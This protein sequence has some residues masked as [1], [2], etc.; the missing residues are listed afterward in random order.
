MS[1]FKLEKI[2]NDNK[3]LIDKS[4]EYMNT[5]TDFEHNSNHIEDVIKYL[6]DIMHNIDN[7]FDAEVCI[8]SAY[9]HDVGRTIQEDNHEKISAE[10]LKEEMM[11]LGYN[12][13]IIEKCFNAVPF[14]KW[15]MTPKTI[16][17]NILKDA[18]KLAWLDVGR[19]S[20]C[21][22][23]NQKLDAIINLLPKLR[24]EILFFEYSKKIYDMEIVNILSLL[25]DEVYKIN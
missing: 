24:N 23:N 25:Y 4:K 22:N 18:D 10:M 16:E 19:W 14:H 6:I 21:I 7:D 9:W 1:K 13:T 17:G 5:I 3:K 12:E 15:N 20:S 11:N 8:I 2:I